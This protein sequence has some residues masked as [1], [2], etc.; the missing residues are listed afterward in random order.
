[1][2]HTCATCMRSTACCECP[3]K[4]T[5][6]E[7]IPVDVPLVP[8]FQIR[9]SLGS[10]L[11]SPFLL[12]RMH[13][14]EGLEGLGEVS[15]TPL[16]SGEDQVTAAHLIANFLAPALTGEDPRDIER[17]T[18]K[19]RR[20]VA[21]NPFTKSALEMALWDILGKSVGLPVYR[22]LGAQG[23][24]DG[25]HQDAGIG[26]GARACGAACRV[27]AGQGSESVEGESGNR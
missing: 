27:G 6:I 14:D 13:T 23:P 15:C 21:A 5:A 19:I 12:V 4:I 25:A 17:L 11:K 2:E 26:R 10:H 18:A 3:M 22:L 7:C 16:W 20:T 9:G 8:E 24:G 1:M